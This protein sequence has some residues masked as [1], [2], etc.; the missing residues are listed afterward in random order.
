VGDAQVVV[1]ST[2]VR[3]DN[4]ERRTRG[5][6]PIPRAGCW[7]LMRL[8]AHRRG[9]RFSPC[10]DHSRWTRSDDCRRR[11]ALRSNAHLGKSDL[12]VATRVTVVSRHAN[13]RSCYQHRS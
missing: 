13:D 2:A 8:A 9:C 6:F 7:R 4:P 1:R 3:E 5:R 11:S 10:G 12:M